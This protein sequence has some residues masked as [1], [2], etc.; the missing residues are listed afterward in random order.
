MPVSGI[1]INE[2]QIESGG[3]QIP[4]YTAEEAMYKITWA[5][6]GLEFR[7]R[8]FYDESIPTKRS[9]YCIE[10]KKYKADESVKKEPDF[11]FTWDIG[12]MEVGCD[13]WKETFREIVRRWLKV[14][15]AKSYGKGV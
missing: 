1:N 2:T 10:D 8:L 14:K 6:E 7:C 5:E 4:V 13:L 3:K 9:L 11:I 15:D 12:D